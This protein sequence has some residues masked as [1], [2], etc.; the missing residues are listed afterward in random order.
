MTD[1]D[2]IGRVASLWNVQYHPSGKRRCLEKQWMPAFA[3]CVKGSRA[4]LLM[5]RLLPLMETRRKKQ[6]EAAPACYHVVPHPTTRMTPE[7]VAQIKTS[8]RENIGARE[9]AA[10][11]QVN[12]STI[13]QI[14]S[15]TNWRWVK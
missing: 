15:G 5:E 11:F 3:V 10:Q 1:E 13:Y 8:S 12:V 14:K 4:V 7:M 2:V 6:I 9:L